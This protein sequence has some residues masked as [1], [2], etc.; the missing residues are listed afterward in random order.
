MLLSNGHRTNNTNKNSVMGRNV[1]LA[2]HGMTESDITL[3]WFA[4]A[5]MVM[6]LVFS[7]N[8]NLKSNGELHFF[9][10]VNTWRERRLI[11]SLIGGHIVI[12][13]AVRFS[14]S[15]SQC[16][17]FCGTFCSQR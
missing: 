4:L 9:L 7:L 11:D 14:K 13:I 2:N 12:S 3:Q 1:I 6:V 16:L 10:F 15:M 5:R 8:Y 17:Y